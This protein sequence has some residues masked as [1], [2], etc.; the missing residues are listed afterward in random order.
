MKRV[1]LPISNSLWKPINR[2]N[3]FKHHQA[4]TKYQTNPLLVPLSMFTAAFAINYYTTK[5]KCDMP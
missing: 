2:Q 1:I 4:F 5:I 3:V